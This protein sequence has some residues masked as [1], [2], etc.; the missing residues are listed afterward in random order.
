MRSLIRNQSTLIFLLMQNEVEGFDG[1]NKEYLCHHFPA[2]MSKKELVKAV[3]ANEGFVGKKSRNF[4]VNELETI[5]LFQIRCESNH[6]D[7]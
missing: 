4:L 2:Y 5:I 1:S 7:D 6:C 3:K